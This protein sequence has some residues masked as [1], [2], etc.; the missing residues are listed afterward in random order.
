MHIPLPSWHPACLPTCAA[1]F[2][3]SHGA[4]HH[5]LVCLTHAA[6][7]IVVV[8]GDGNAHHCV[9]PDPARPESAIHVAGPAGLQ[10]VSEA[11]SERPRHDPHPSA[12]T[13]HFVKQVL[14]NTRDAAMQYLRSTAWRAAGPGSLSGSGSDNGSEG[15]GPQGRLPVVTMQVLLYPCL[16]SARDVHAGSEVACSSLH[17]P[18]KPCKHV[19]D[20]AWGV[21]LH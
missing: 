17:A 11:P 1:P 2:P 8:L 15:H 16:H 9:H 13:Q 20:R 5:A 21:E 3:F 14:A 18:S 6:R 12:I 4:A 19:H 10:P 7:K